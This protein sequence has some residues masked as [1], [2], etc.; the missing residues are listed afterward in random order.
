MYGI[1]CIQVPARTVRAINRL[2][3]GGYPPEGESKV[4]LI[5]MLGLTAVAAVA[6]MAFIGASSA[7]ADNV[8]IVL[9]GVAELAC[10]EANQLPNPT[11]VGHATNPKL[12]SSIGT[13]ECE[14]SLAELTVLNELSELLLGHILALSFE[15]NCHLGG[16]S[17]TVT[18]NTLGLVS[19]TKTG[20]LSGIA[21]STGGTKAT[22]KCGSFINC[23]Y[24]GEPALELSSTAGGETSMVANKTVLK[25]G[26]FLCPST[27]EWDATYTGEVDLKVVNK[28]GKEELVS[29]PN[30]WIES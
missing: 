3:R 20:A 6:A 23:S 21:K 18:V 13:V 24:A 29:D 27:S 15:G 8:H 28:E 10:E 2:G 7:S 12:L 4:R 19:A 1:A 5:K 14:K 17:C 25:G 9:C 30:I 16:T 22:V 26:G 11:I